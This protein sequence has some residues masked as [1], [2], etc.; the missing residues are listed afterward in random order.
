M[1]SQTP[2]STTVLDTAGNL[3]GGSLRNEGGAAEADQP[4][5]GFA[6]PPPN[7]GNVSDRRL[8]AKLAAQE[9]KDLARRRKELNRQLWSDR[10]KRVHKSHYIAAG[11][12]VC[13]GIGFLAL[14][15]VLG[16]M[17]SIAEANNNDPAKTEQTPAPVVVQG[18]ENPLEQLGLTYPARWMIGLDSNEK[19][20]PGRSTDTMVALLQQLD[21]CGVYIRL[22]DNA[23]VELLGAPAAGAQPFVECPTGVQ[24]TPTTVEV[25][26]DPMPTTTVPKG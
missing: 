6:P 13:A 17:L 16:T 26:A 7:A 8:A 12:I 11:G 24:T 18:I 21:L 22:G 1:N 23:Q 3:G 19:L 25:P 14:K 9:A 5:R 2:R 4:G 10:L 20:V 15:S